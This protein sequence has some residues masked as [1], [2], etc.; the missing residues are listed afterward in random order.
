MSI[1]PDNQQPLPFSE[2][3]LK[4]LT[5][6]KEG[7][8]VTVEAK[9]R[10]IRLFRQTFDASLSDEEAWQRFEK[11]YDQVEWSNVGTLQKRAAMA[12][13]QF[14]R[15]AGFVTP[16]GRVNLTWNEESP[17]PLKQVPIID[18]PSSTVKWVRAG[19]YAVIRVTQRKEQELVLLEL[20]GRIK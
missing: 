18:I 1:E 16:D 6:L 5:D 10:G 12:R 17:P 11:I 13:K 19:E 9:S 14:Y 3:E 2:E 4:R 15:W 8:A 20:I 7:I